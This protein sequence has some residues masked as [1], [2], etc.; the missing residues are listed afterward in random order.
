MKYLD[1]IKGYFFGD[2]RSSRVTKNILFSFFI[3]GYAMFIQFALVPITLEYLDK[4]H[5][6]IWLVLASI[7]EWF[8]Y[9]DIGVGHGLRNKLSEALA[10]NDFKLAKI[11]TSTAYALSTIIFSGFIFI[12][13]IIN[14]FLDWGAILNVSPN[15]SAELGEMAFFVFAFFCIRF[16][17]NLIT[18]IIYAKQDPAIRN[19]MGPLGSTISLVAIVLLSKYV[20]GSLFWIALIFS[21][22]PLLVFL[23]TSLVL[24]STRYKALKPNIKFVDFSYSGKLVGLGV[25]FFI[26][27][28]SMLILFSSANIILTQLYGPEE[29]AVYNIAYKYFTIGILINGIVT[30]PYWSSFTEA[31]FKNDVEWIK[32]SMKKLNLISLLLI[33]G[34]IILLLLADKIVYLWVGEDVTIPFLMKIVLTLYVSIH[35]LAVPYNIFINGVSKIRLQL[36]VALISIV[37]TIP[38]ALFF[39]KTL[40][41]GPSGVVLAMVCSTLPGGILWWIQ[42][43]KLIDGKATGIWDV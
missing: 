11:F 4:F 40:N 28:V 33:G 24:F 14:P 30:L 34:Q 13:A 3:K 23:V 1:S 17:L 21:G 39:C 18:S 32:T 31:Y 20:S 26:I 36:Y 35:L 15:E 41:I 38:L 42:Y 43:H 8:S 7:L 29:V 16:I 9:F 10:L 12:F 22:S 5:Y 6:G 2:Q 19:F 25:G 27:Q 37:V